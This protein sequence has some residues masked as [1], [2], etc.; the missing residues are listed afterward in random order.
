MDSNKMIVERVFALQ[1]AIQGK[2]DA[3]ALALQRAIMPLLEYPEPLASAK[4]TALLAL[5]GIGPKVVDLVLRVIAGEDIDAIAE[6][7][8]SIPRNPQI[9]TGQRLAPEN[10]NWDGSWDNAVKTAEDN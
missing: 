1:K 10:G 2:N 7:I 8:P 5:H 6:S 4:R 3:R 9:R